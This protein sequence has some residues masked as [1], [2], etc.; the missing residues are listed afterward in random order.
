MLIHGKG[1]AL[2]RRRVGESDGV[3]LVLLEDGRS[4]DLRGH[5]ILRS[6]NRS[7]LLFEPGCLIRFAA[8]LAEG[9]GAVA[10]DGSL[11][12]S[13][14]EGSVLDRYEDLKADYEA[15]LVLALFLES[16]TRACRALAPL[17][18]APSVDPEGE[19]VAGARELYRLAQGALEQLR[20]LRVLENETKAVRRTASLQS[21][22]ANASRD[23]ESQA[24]PEEASFILRLLLLLGFYETRLLK[25]LGLLGDPQHCSS[26]GAPLGE[27]ASWALP[28]AHFRCSRCS[29]AA[30]ADEAWMAG[31]IRDAAYRRFGRLEA[32]RL[33]ALM[34]RA[35]A[36]KRAAPEMLEEWRLR[37]HRCLVMFFGQ[38]LRSDRE[39]EAWLIR[40]AQGEREAQL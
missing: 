5:G 15:M 40:A 31:M 7:N 19:A 2:Q 20:E 4:L 23:A 1:I 3:A 26:C 13:L 39:G 22:T 11:F 33:P 21:P 34:E 25:V 30:N 27:E 14:K 9:P 8:Y 28:E 24:R 36:E 6:K 32:M 16:A 37:L 38:P 18:N 17:A 10:G 35:R 29:D 12:A